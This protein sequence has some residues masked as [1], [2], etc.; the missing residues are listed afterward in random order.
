MKF[1]PSF[2]TID[3]F[4]LCA[5]SFL[6]F[7]SFN[8]IIPE[9]PAY[10]TSLGGAE[11]KGLI[12]SLFTLS[13]GLSRPFSGKL[14]DKIGRIP[15][16]MFGASV[17]FV[18]S[19]LYPLMSFVSGFL[20]LRFIHGFSTGF[21]PTGTSAY[22]ADIVPFQR[23]GEAMGIQSLFGSLGMAAGPAIG[24]W[25]ASIWPIEILF[26]SASFTAI[27]S[28]LILLKLKETLE[29]KE[30]LRLGLFKLKRDELIEKRVLAPSLVLFFSVFSFGVVLTIIPDFSAHLG[31]ANK[32]LFFAVFTLSSLGIRLIAGKASDRYGRIP[33]LRAATLFMMGSMVLI[34]FSETK[35]ALMGAGVM[36]GC[37]VGMNSP[38][39]AAWV[40]DRSLNAYRGRALAT[41]YIFLEAGIGIGAVVSGWLFANEVENFK[42]VFLTAASMAAVALL[43]LFFVKEKTRFEDKL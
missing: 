36:F 31:I 23:R 32:G 2:F 14:A 13:A 24:G 27:L 40:I 16:M 19:L 25:I 22:V 20:F 39:T 28:I 21:T 29:E 35:T 7:S 12:I 5:S 11:Y 33:V 43:V 3:F 26:Y 1:L 10:L 4:L 30:P 6:F 42:L 37:A 38:T 34:A 18:I 17:C 15:V 8:M 9:L 41:M